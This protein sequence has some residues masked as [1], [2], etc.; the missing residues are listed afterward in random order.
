MG[1]RWSRQ[2]QEVVVAATAAPPSEKEAFTGVEKLVSTGV[3]DKR[4]G[5]HEEEAA[6][7]CT[8][9]DDEE[10]ELPK[11]PEPVLPLSIEVRAKL[12][13]A[14]Q[15]ILLHANTATPVEWVKQQVEDQ[16]NTRT[17]SNSS[18]GASSS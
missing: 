12:K 17:K 6:E 11:E 15:P 3:E 14:Q 1:V 13:R 7:C 8:E 10:N 18:G 4:P 5:E 16:L 2:T 9:E